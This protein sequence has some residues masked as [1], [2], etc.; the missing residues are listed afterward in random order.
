[1]LSGKLHHA[2]FVIQ[3][4]RYFVRRL[5]RLSDLHLSGAERTSGGGK[6]GAGAESGRKRGGFNVCRVNSWLTWG[7]GDGFWGGGEGTWGRG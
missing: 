5:L 3:P 2:S 6:S 1:M 4:G 7:G